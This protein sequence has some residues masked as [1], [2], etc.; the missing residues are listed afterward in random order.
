MSTLRGEPERPLHTSY[1]PPGGASARTREE[2]RE[3]NRAAHW[4]MRREE[5]AARMARLQ[6]PAPE[7]PPPPKPTLDRWSNVLFAFHHEASPNDGHAWTQDEVTPTTW[8]REAEGAE[9]W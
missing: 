7:A 1:T 8:W 5:Q 9:R 6:P 2:R 4:A 3:A